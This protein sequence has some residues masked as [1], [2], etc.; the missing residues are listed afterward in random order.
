MAPQVPHVLRA[1]PE[2]GI[3]AAHALIVDGLQLTDISHQN[4][5]QVPTR[6]VGRVEGRF[7]EAQ[8]L[9]LLQAAD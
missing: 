3:G 2:R 5:G 9:C 7:A 6:V 4:Y 8:P 1:S